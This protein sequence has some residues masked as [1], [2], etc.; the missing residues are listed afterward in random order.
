M[1]F[2]SPERLVI[3][4]AAV[5]GERLVNGTFSVSAETYPQRCV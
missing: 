3:S 2:R 5:N 1:F 4:A